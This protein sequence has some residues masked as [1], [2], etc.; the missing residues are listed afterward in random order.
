MPKV[1]LMPKVVRI[2]ALRANSIFFL[3]GFDA[4]GTDISL[5]NYRHH[6]RAMDLL[7]DAGNECSALCA[8][9]GASGLSSSV[10]LRGS[11]HA[12]Q[13]IRRRALGALDVSILGVYQPN[14]PFLS[15]YLRPYDVVV[16]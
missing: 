12:V 2:S 5:Q 10:V 3:T 15:T 1:I 11:V 7:I 9:C 13:F 8:L 16:S 14:A 4:A 6:N